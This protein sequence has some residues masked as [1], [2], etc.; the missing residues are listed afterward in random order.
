[1]YFYAFIDNISGQR[2]CLVF[3]YI[4]SNLVKYILERGV[5]LMYLFVN[6]SMKNS[7]GIFDIWLFYLSN[8]LYYLLID[9]CLI[10]TKNQIRDHVLQSYNYNNWN[11]NIRM[12]KWRVDKSLK[13]TQISQLERMKCISTVSPKDLFSIYLIVILIISLSQHL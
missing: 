7:K 3:N 13:E 2:I 8:I 4:K 5:T 11:M 6:I 10:S 1:M 12:L 9:S